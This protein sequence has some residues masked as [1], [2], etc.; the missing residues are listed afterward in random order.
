MN[1]T[2]T[3]FDA[4]VVGTGIAGMACALAMARRG[5]RVSLLGPRN[6]LPAFADGQYDPRVYAISPASREFLSTLGVWGA[7]P[8]ARF[9][10]VEAMEVYGDN[11]SQLTL[12]AWQAGIAELASIVESTE[13]ERAL[14]AALQVFGVPWTPGRFT[15]LTRRP[16]DSALELQTD[17][18]N[19]IAT[20]LAV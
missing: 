20:R 4:V 6:A 16:D 14:R 3:S 8:A 15:G 17:S 18:G 19:R 12:S 5:V 1:P 2:P 9:S 10:P 11:S 13:L 7:L